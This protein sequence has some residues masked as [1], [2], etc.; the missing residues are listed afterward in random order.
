MDDL[1]HPADSEF[2]KRIMGAANR[3]LAD[4]KTTDRLRRQV[5]ERI[6]TLVSEC[7]ALDSE[8]DFMRTERLL[9]AAW[10][11][12]C[13]GA[14]CGK[15]QDTLGFENAGRRGAGG[16]ASGKTRRDSAGMWENHAGE[17]MKMLRSGEPH[18]S[19]EKVAERVADLWK[20]SDEAPGHSSLVKLLRKLE[21]DGVVATKK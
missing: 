7:N 1:P 13:I 2:V 18:L 20:L 19:Q 9:S 6:A 5:R 14:I 3:T 8:G 12:F 15:H 21:R 17:L 16:R 11:A 4:N 10:G